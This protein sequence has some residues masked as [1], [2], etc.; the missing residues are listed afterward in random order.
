MF[1]NCDWG[2]LE[3]NHCCDEKHRRQC[4]WLSAVNCSG[5]AW[6]PPCYSVVWCQWLGCS[7]LLCNEHRWGM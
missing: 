5:K 2:G 3:L 6:F 1:N 7:S 4:G